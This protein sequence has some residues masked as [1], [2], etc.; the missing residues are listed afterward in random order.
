MDQLTQRLKNMTPLQRAVFALKETQS[1]LD[2]L[3]Q[4]RT[5][6]IAIVGMACRFP[7]GAI[8]PVSYWRLLR[9]GVDAI[10]E[11]PADRWNVDEFY[12]ADPAAPGKMC[13]R[14][15]GFLSDIDQFDNRFFSISDTEATRM[16]PQQRILLELAWEALEDAGLPP[17]KLRGE[18]IG[19][20]VGIS[21]SE[22]GLMMSGDLTQTGAHTA[23]GTSLCLAA[24]RLSFAFGLHGPSMALDTACSS[25]LVAIHLACQSIR[26]GECDG[27]LVGGA[28]LLLSPIGTI[29]LTKAGFCATDGRVRAFD[30][31]ASGYVRSEG[32]GLVMLKPLSAALKNNDLIYAVI[33][34]SAINQ[35]GSSNGITA[36]SRAAQE[37]VLREAYARAQVSP[38]QV[39]FVEA[40][41]TGTPLGDTIEALALGSVLAQDREPDN[42]CALG[43]LKTNIGH[44]EA[45]SGI[46]S[47]MKAAL[48]L[49]H[50]QLVP[51]LH[52][53]KPNPEIPFSSLPLQVQTRLE[54]WPDSAHRRY[55]GVNAFGF[56]GSNAHVVLEERPA[57]SQVPAPA[58]QGP[59]LL[60][61]S[62]RT[63]KAMR[64][65][66]DRYIDFLRNDPP[67]WAD[68]CHTA[69]TRRE[70]H[71]C[72]VTVLANSC[73]EAVELLG[74]SL[75]DTT[76]A[77]VFVGRK[78]FDRGL[79]VAFIF[80]DDPD[81]WIPIAAR[82]A[83]DVPGFAAATEEID[84]A[85]QQ[86]VG[87]HLAD[88]RPDDTRWSDKCWA[89]P[90]LLAMQ[91]ALTAWWRRI[92]VAPDVVL[93]QGVGE[94]AAASVAGILTP[95]EALHFARATGN[96]HSSPAQ[97]RPAALPF[98]SSADGKRHSGTDLD[99]AHWRTCTGQSHGLAEAVA[100]IAQRNVDIWLEPGAASLA[101]STRQL[102]A[103][104]HP[105]GRLV[106]SL[107][108]R[109]ANRS[110]ILTAIGTLYAAG[111]DPIW[112][113]LTPDTARFVRAP[114]Y[115]WQRQ[116][117]WVS[118]LKRPAHSE[119][120][121]AS[122]SE[123]HDVTQVRP[124]PD[125]TVPYAE[126]RTPLETAMI[127]AWSEIL[128]LDGIGIYDNFFELGGDSLQATILLNHLQQELGQSVPG[129]ALFQVQT[130][131]D[132]A[133][134]LRTHC[135][136]AVQRRYPNEV[137]SPDQTPAVATDGP[138][139]IPRLTRDQKAD[140][141]LTRLDDLSDEE[142][143]LLLGQAA[144]DGEV[145]HE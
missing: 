128:Q 138:A 143:E 103:Q 69:A 61:L 6:P 85:C 121:Q 23:S 82:L 130:V 91:L 112:E 116:S 109:E 20:F 139:S 48:T 142:I 29:N 51:N 44:L 145:S 144:T 60:P 16:D 86:V 90:A 79:K 8:D 54:P 34:S 141:L 52:F 125:L 59:H 41:A 21:V 131:N 72:R 76:P 80:G 40:Q 122:P 117:L 99:A 137:L 100:A 132:L 26:N 136:D 140:E 66:I 56:G 111:A 7:G 113:R 42:R 53:Q 105:A 49:E 107:L 33:R 17:S 71:D 73:D 3:E 77:G 83:C 9:D 28:N 46:A 92:G 102:L 118:G 35:N 1:R 120:V 67:A 11:I 123:T 74:H 43:A 96:G 62:A 68:I 57:E 12:D 133:E 124:R 108:P 15:G 101:Q 89:R 63:D 22:Y 30:A 36:P 55:A 104:H 95:E 134:Y 24:N 97:A 50:R 37:Q 81:N 126:P 75:D 58:V 27:A 31:S 87:C 84:A 119:P 47:L 94:L 78:P 10:G 18:K 14:W 127:Q 98:L 2:A 25:S 129:H 19:V 110:D 32:A 4:K 65:L 93:G 135:R 70:H 115:P 114:K 38:G 13:T 106:A 88:L 5:E 64:D 39:Q 45:A